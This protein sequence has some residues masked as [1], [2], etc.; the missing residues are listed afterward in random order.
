LLLG[1]NWD[2]YETSEIPSSESEMIVLINEKEELSLDPD[3][4][5]IADDY[6]H[7][8]QALLATEKAVAAGVLDIRVL[9]I[10]I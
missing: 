5:L 3:G 4:L 1:S 8:S 7:L 10:C 2:K 6:L 9:G